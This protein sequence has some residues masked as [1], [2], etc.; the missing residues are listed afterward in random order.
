MDKQ[1]RR[2]RGKESA[3]I[4]RIRPLIVLIFILIF[5]T[6]GEEAKISRGSR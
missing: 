4:G 5:K 1:R 3:P 2:K 6:K